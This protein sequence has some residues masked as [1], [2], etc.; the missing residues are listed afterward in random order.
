MVSVAKFSYQERLKMINAAMEFCP[1]CQR[2]LA[3]F[4]SDKGTDVF[5]LIR[6][7]IWKWYGQWPHGEGCPPEVPARTAP[8][9]LGSRQAGLTAEVPSGLHE[10]P[11]TQNRATQSA[12][13]VDTMGFTSDP[14]SGRL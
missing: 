5:G 7:V 3:K 11:E 12:V 9:A 13:Q 8:D 1:E 10:V 2:E 14:G 6:E 4:A